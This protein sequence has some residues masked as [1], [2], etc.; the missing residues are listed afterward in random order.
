M[1]DRIIAMVDDGLKVLPFSFLIMIT[2]IKAM[3]K[4]AANV[5]D[6]AAPIAPMIGIVISKS[7]MRTISVM[8]LLMRL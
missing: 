2:A 7:A 3:D 6:I 8:R 5:S 1:T 4:R